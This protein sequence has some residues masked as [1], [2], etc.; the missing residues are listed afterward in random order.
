MTLA[1]N[2]RTYFAQAKTHAEPC[3][4]LVALKLRHLVSSLV[5]DNVDPVARTADGHYL[6]DAAYSR[7][8]DVTPAFS[9]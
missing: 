8:P 4:F 9:S 7:N 5:N 6:H 3:Q 2:L 1:E